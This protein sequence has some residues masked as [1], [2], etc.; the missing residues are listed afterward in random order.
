MMKIGRMTHTSSRKKWDMDVFQWSSV[1]TW[2]QENID[3]VTPP[4]LYTT[5]QNVN[6]IYFKTKSKNVEVGSVFE[7]VGT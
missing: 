4:N 5:K 3:F 6:T 2:N 7:N 1:I